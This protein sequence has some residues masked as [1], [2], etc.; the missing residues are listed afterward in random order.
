MQFTEEVNWSV[1]DF[2]IGGALLFLVGLALNV[3]WITIQKKEHRIILCLVI[4]FLFVLIWAELAV[5]IFNSR[6][7]GS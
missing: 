7:A 2:I 5:G 1:F 6:F 4:L 3:A